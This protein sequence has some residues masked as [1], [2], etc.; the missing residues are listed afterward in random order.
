MEYNWETLTV[1]QYQQLLQEGEDLKPDRLVE[2]LTGKSK[3]QMTVAEFENVRIGNIQPPDDL[4]W[5]KIILHNGVYY[6]RV[7]MDTLSYGEFVDLMDYGK[8]PAKNLVE[9]VAL[10]YRPITEFPTKSKLQ[11]RLAQYL[12][13]TASMGNRYKWIYNLVEKAR[14]SVE[15]YDPIKCDLRHKE[16]KAFPAHAAHYCLTF[17]LTYYQL[18]VADS[19]KSS[20]DKMKAAIKATT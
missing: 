10:I 18:S 15:Q 17:F 6:G 5:N 8:D 11:I 2:I 7:D 3:L 19:L 1:K 16:I 9:I 12:S 14:F 4:G 13:Q 20:V